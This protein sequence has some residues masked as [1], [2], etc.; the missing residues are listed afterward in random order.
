M[1]KAFGLAARVQGLERYYALLLG[2]GQQARL[3]KNF[4]GR[5]V[6][7]EAPFK[8]EVD[9]EYNLRLRVADEHITAWINDKQ[10]FDLEDQDHRIETGGVAILVE[11]GRIAAEAVRVQPNAG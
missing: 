1:V 6:L 10:L 5:T 3:E 2:P 7:A 8:W 9:Q 4:N 11:E